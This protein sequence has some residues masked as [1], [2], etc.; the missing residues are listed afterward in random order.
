MMARLKNNASRYRRANTAAHVPRNQ[1]R[2]LVPIVTRLQLSLGA[3]LGRTANKNSTQQIT[4][5]EILRVKNCYFCS[6]Y[7]WCFGVQR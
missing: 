2:K 6:F 7:N 4:V 5:N 1:Y 3:P